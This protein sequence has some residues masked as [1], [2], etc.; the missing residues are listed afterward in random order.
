M[1]LKE[2]LRSHLAQSARANRRSLNGEITYRLEESVRADASAG[3]PAT[4]SF[5]RFAATLIERAERKSGKSWNEDFATWAA[6]GAALRFA[7]NDFHPGY[8]ELTDEQWTEIERA[9]DEVDR[10][11]LQM[12]QTAPM[13]LTEAQER[14]RAFDAARAKSRALDPFELPEKAGAT[15][16]VEGKME[17]LR[18][19]EDAPA[20]T[21]VPKWFARRA[22][23]RR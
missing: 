17:A 11:R 9:R 23:Q 10:L 3:S 19:D 2:A 22:Q 18:G 15:L 20:R 13:T 21:E 7:H 8:P 12:E 4:A 16:Y 5:L 1:R 14:F 6:V